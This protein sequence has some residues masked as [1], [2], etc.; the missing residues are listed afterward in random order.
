[1]TPKWM[2]TLR[3]AEQYAKLGGRY[4]HAERQHVGM[5]PINRCLKLK[6]AYVR[7]GCLRANVRGR[8]ELK[9]RG[10]AP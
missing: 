7:H 8:A 6:L 9:R 4:I 10:F 3:R 2:W 5:R 1:M